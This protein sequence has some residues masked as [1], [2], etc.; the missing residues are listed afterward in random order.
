MTQQ[1]RKEIAL[2]D[3]QLVAVHSKV[4]MRPGD[5]GNAVVH[6][7]RFEGNKIV[8]LRDVG[9]AVPETTENEHGMF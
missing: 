8:E 7:F 9:Q 3:G 2:E 5:R 6:L 1:R 4:T